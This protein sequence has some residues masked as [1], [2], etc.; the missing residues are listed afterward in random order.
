MLIDSCLEGRSG[1]PKRRFNIVADLLSEVQAQLLANLHDRLMRS[2]MQGLIDL[3]AVTNRDVPYV[4]GQLAVGVA[5]AVFRTRNAAGEFAAHEIILLAIFL[6]EQAGHGRWLVVGA[7]WQIA[8][9][10]DEVR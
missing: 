10:L 9:S 5:L 4:A 8:I 7:P 2:Q 6:T 1:D 3:A